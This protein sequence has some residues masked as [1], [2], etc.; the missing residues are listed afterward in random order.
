MNFLPAVLVGGPPNAGKS[1]LL[2]R[3]TQ[4]LRARGVDHYALRACPDGEGNWFQESDPAFVSTILVKH[5]IWPTSFLERISQDLEHRC[6][7]FL[8]DMGGHPTPAEASLFRSCTHTILLLREDLPQETQRWQEVVET[9]NLL[10]LARLFSQREGTSILLTSSPLLTG[11]L[12][13]LDRHMP[14][15]E[16][17]PLFDALVQRLV[18]LFTSYDVR[19]QLIAHLDHAPTELT[20][21]V[22]QELRTFTTSSTWEPEMLLPFLNRLPEALPLSVYGSGPSWLYA[23]LAAY[24]DPQPLYLFDPKQPFGWVQPVNVKLHKEPVQTSEIVL[25]TR[26]TPGCTILKM[27]F[28]QDRLAYFQPEPLAFPALPPGNGVIL[29]GRAPNWLLTA[30]VRLYKAADAAW[31][32]PFYVQAQKAI[33]VFSHVES[34]QIGECID[35]SR[36]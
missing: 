24:N 27:H 7:P 33:V 23:A 16:T 22:Q 15:T 1:V 3:L 4:A 30:L 8:V 20:V 36:Y 29:D 13:G 35:P 32:A 14:Q 9:S 18:Q 2:Y 34:P 5:R 26:E 6:L 10:P 21:N 28:P 17:S 19:D 31:I 11:I 12:T 25:T